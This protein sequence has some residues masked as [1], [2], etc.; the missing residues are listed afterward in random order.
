MAEGVAGQLANVAAAIPDVRGELEKEYADLLNYLCDGTKLLY[1]T[2]GV[3]MEVSYCVVAVLQC[4]CT[5]PLPALPAQDGGQAAQ[6]Q[7][8]RDG[9]SLGDTCDVFVDAADAWYVSPVPRRCQQLNATTPNPAPAE[10]AGC[11]PVHDSLRPALVMRPHESGVP[12]RLCV[13]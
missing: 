8:F 6:D 2:H 13:A 10:R 11:W 3:I 1:K 4:L 9:L 12:M 5:N 7:A